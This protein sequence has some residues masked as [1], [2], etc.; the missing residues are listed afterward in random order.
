MN[1]S[2]LMDDD[3]VS[4]F[5]LATTL[6]R[7]WRRIAIWALIGAVTGI[8]TATTIAPM[9]AAS[10][11]FVPQG[12]DA[13]RSGLGALA[14]QFGV[15]LPTG[16]NLSQS[17]E[18]YAELLKSRELLRPIAKSSISVRD[19]AKPVP[20]VKL[21]EITKG[22]AYERDEAAVKTLSGMIST[23]VSKT[24]GVVEIRVSSRLRGVSLAILSALIDGLNS[25]NLRKR[26]TQAA[27]ER[28]FA[29]GRATIVASDLRSAEDRLEAF[30]QANKSL[31][32]PQLVL[33]RD[34]LQRAVNLQ[35][36]LLTSLA[37]AVEDA[38]IREVRDTPVITVINTPAMLTSA[39]PVGRL[40]GRKNRG[41]LGIL[42]GGIIGALLAFASE[43]MSRRRR[44]GDPAAEEFVA[45]LRE[46]K[47][48]VLRVL[49]RSGDQ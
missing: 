1:E 41:L 7:N 5:V 10:A 29:E 24:T 12:A 45:T 8:I 14:G 48:Q 3:E 22:S 39:E 20:F 33:Q 6:L 42:L 44:A 23:S 28:R 40:S 9:Y 16:N 11:S 15:T 17:P 19:G 47:R 13:P 37:Q 38:R 30:L 35:Q 31:T 49:S 21:F 46:A 34:R 32:A 43:G 2:G 26:Q 36:Q 25:F 4:V 18:F 27:A